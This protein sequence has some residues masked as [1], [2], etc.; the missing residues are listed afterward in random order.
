MRPLAS[1]AIA[2]WCTAFAVVLPAQDLTGPP[3]TTADPGQLLDACLAA[4]DPATATSLAAALADRGAAAA[5]LVAR[6]VAAI[7]TRTEPVRSHLLR[8]LANGAL[9]TTAAARAAASQE[10]PQWLCTDLLL[11][12]APDRP[13]F[14]FYEAT[15]LA[16]RLE[17][18]AAGTT[19]DDLVGSL[20][21]LRQRPRTAPTAVPPGLAN[22][23]DHYTFTEMTDGERETVEAVAELALAHPGDVRPVLEELTTYLRRARTVPMVDRC[24]VQRSASATTPQPVPPAEPDAARATAPAAVGPVLWRPD[25]WRLAVANTLFRRHP[26]P[27]VQT[28]ALHHLL[29]SWDAAACL[30][31]VVAVRQL[32]TVPAAM[33]TDL[34][35]LLARKDRALV[36]ETLLTLAQSR[37]LARHA[38]ASLARIARGADEELA[39]LARR[40][41]Q[42]LER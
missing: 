19:P 42:L 31:A 11:A 16:R 37:A 10:L 32:A 3:A 29:L 14:A 5:P 28:L 24:L 8:A 21:H 17:L 25:A 26:A 4:D 41:Q 36:R 20:A 22:W 35:S 7:P 38:T 9:T 6:L 23:D 30:E 12:A 13:T 27:A 2:A 1:T 33:A 34:A 18:V 39:Q 40:A 15:R